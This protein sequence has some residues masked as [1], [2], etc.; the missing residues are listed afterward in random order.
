MKTFLVPLLVASVLT[1]VSFAGAGPGPWAN[2]T[3]YPGNL[4]GKYQAAVVGNN[5]SGVLGF[6]LRDGGLPIL[7]ATSQTNASNAPV[8]TSLD[9]D[10]SLNYFAVFVEGRTYTGSTAAGVNYDSGKVTGAMIGQQPVATFLTNTNVTTFLTTQTITN[11]SVTNQVTT[12]ITVTNA[13]GGSITNEVIT[14]NSF[15]NFSIDTV[16]LTNT[17][18]QS[19]TM[20]P[21]F[22]VNRGL[23][24]GFQAKIK[25]KTG[26]FTFKGNGQ[27]STPAQAQT[28]NLTTNAQGIITGAE[29]DTQ[30]VAFQVDGIRVSP[31]SAS[32]LPTNAAAAAPAN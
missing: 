15:T 12:N 3:Y 4:D 23:N 18:P 8:N 2:G 24:G 20:D 16:I 28:V 22:L 1:S 7:S 13:F 11:S 26:V 10:P 21:A 31:L 14:T 19:S 29:I 5:I 6:A 30:T 17:L 27:L 25:S 9:L 32:T